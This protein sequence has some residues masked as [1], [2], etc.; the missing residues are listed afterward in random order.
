MAVNIKADT[1]K[2]VQERSVRLSMA[3]RIRFWIPVALC[4]GITFYA[5]SI[6]GKDIPP[7]FPYKEIVYHFFIYLALAFFFC[8]ALKNTRVQ[9]TFA[10]AVL[11]TLFFI[12]L[13]GLSDEFHQL[14]TPKRSASGF[15][16]LIDSLG[17]F[18][19]SVLYPW[20]R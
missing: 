12:L 2:V 8:R 15:D 3:E 11:I 4:M 9:M 13:Y 18:L 14:F 1:A 17:G 20:L 10:R 19:G 5:S 16:L 7:L 6:P